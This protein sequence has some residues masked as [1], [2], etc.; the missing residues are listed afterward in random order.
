MVVNPWPISKARTCSYGGTFAALIF[1]LI[2]SGSVLYRLKTPSCGYSKKIIYR[3]SVLILAIS[4][5]AVVKATDY[6][7][8]RIV[9]ETKD[10]LHQYKEYGKAN[11]AKRRHSGK[12]GCSS[13]RG[14]GLRRMAGY[15]S[16]SSVNRNHGIIWGLMAMTEI[17]RHG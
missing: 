3:L 15:L 1:I 2:G 10:A 7:P 13:C 4:G 8:V 11:M 5:H 6:L 17:R 16:W 12:P 14:L 9:T